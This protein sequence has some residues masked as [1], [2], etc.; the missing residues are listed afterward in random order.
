M[1]ARAMWKMLHLLYT[2]KPGVTSLSTQELAAAGI[3][4]GPDTLTPLE[5]T[6]AVV[7]QGGNYSLT[8]PA[9]GI[10]QTC[11]VSNRRWPGSDMWVDYPEVFVVMPFS[12]PWSDTVYQTMLKPAIEGAEF[13][14]V[15]GDTPVRVGDLTQ[16]IWNALMRAGLIVADVSAANMNV[17]YEIGLAHALGKDV[18][19]LKQKAA[20]IPADFG[21]VH[22]YE[23][24]LNDL[25]AGREALRT[26]IKKWG[27]ENAVKGVKSIR[28]R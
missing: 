15:R 14:C 10:L 18:F 27:E 4:C 26:E 9:L 12:Q 17:F 24:D 8:P 3:D 7:N 13:A 23:Y 28:D 19:I 11:V 2:L 5:Q 21:G 20:Q 16:T 6:G 1:S 25:D 22:Y